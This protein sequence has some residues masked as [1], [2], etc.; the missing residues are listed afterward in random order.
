[1]PV[2]GWFTLPKFND[3]PATHWASGT[4]KRAVLY[5]VA[6][7]YPDGN[8][9]PDAQVSRA[10]AATMATKVMDRTLILAGVALAAVIMAR[11]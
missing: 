10:E 4:I 2:A 8:F 6:N 1:M 7:G 5:G 9:K 3:V 11:K